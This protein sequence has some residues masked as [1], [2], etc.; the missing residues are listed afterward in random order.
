MNKF[1]HRLLCKKYEQSATAMVQELRKF[2]HHIS[3][4]KTDS[5][6]EYEENLKLLRLFLDNNGVPMPKPKWH[7]DDKDESTWLFTHRKDVN[8]NFLM[9]RSRRR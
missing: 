1:V 3:V 2:K 6:I 7:Y 9:L 8:T 4:V 5:I